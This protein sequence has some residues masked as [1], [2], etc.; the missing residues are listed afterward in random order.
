MVSLCLFAAILV[1][2]VDHVAGD[3]GAPDMFMISW[4]NTLLQ[5]IAGALAKIKEVWGVYIQSDA[6]FKAMMKDLIGPQ[7]KFIV[8]AAKHMMD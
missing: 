2:V 7:V 3:S 8:Q 1:L 6:Q 5:T 4:I